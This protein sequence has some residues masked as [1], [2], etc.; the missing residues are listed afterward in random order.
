MVCTHRTKTLLEQH[1][2]RMAKGGGKQEKAANRPWS[3][4]V[5]MCACVIQYVHMGGNCLFFGLCPA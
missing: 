2:E 3:R 4:C 1:Q 5:C